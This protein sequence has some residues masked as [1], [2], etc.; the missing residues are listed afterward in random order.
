MDQAIEMTS[1]LLDLLPQIIVGIKVEH[2]GH[3]VKSILVVGDLG[4][5]AREVEPV[6]EVILIDFA[7]VFI[8]SR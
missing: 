5:Q 7:E 1:R 2:V 8:S 4:V 6:C 3:Q